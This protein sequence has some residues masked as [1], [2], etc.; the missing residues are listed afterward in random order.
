M[1]VVVIVTVAPMPWML[2]SLGIAA[3]TVIVNGMVVPIWMI[4]FPTMKALKPPWFTTEPD[5]A[6]PQIEIH[7]AHQ[8]HIFVTVPDVI[9]RNL[10][11]RHWWRSGRFNDHAAIGPNHAT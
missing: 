10:H 5:I 1:L 4:P 11:H 8:A 3:V 7:T 9:V 6:W 2:M